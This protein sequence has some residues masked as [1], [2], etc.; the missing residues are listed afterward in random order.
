MKKSY[1]KIVCRNPK[2]NFVCSDEKSYLMMK[3]SYVVKSYV[4]NCQNRIQKITKY[5]NRISKITIDQNRIQ[6]I[7]KYQN[8]MQTNVKIVCSQIVCKQLSKSYLDNLEI[9][10]SYLKNFGMSKSYVDKCQNRMQENRM[11]SIFKIVY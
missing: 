10:K 3:K 2:K 9:S 11:Q 1:I 8:R 7:S 6:K 4:E 5:Q